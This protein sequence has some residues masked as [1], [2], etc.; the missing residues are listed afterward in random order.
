MLSQTPVAAT[1]RLGASLLANSRDTHAGRI[2][3]SGNHVHLAA[4]V[5]LGTLLACFI[6]A[7][8]FLFPDPI[9]ICIIFLPLNMMAAPGVS[10]TGKT[11][12]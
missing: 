3:R 11:P 12:V 4:T 5:L 10:S 9:C 2:G 6:I 1:R 7:S 8:W